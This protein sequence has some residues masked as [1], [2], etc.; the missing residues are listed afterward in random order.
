MRRHLYSFMLRNQCGH[1]S[2]S[3]LLCVNKKTAHPSVRERRVAPSQSELRF[4]AKHTPHI[5]PCGPP[6]RRKAPA[7][8]ATDQPRLPARRQRTQLARSSKGRQD[9][10]QACTQGCLST[11]ILLREDNK[12]DRLHCSVIGTEMVESGAF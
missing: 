8:T 3:S 9:D 6:L 5:A 1:F 11:A 4:T 12:W 7:V 2:S 10:Q